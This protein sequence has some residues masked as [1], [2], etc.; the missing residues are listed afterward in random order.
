[1]AALLLVL[2]LA[3]SAAADDPVR[4][5]AGRDGETCRIVI[6]GRPYSLPADEARIAAHLQSVKRRQRRARLVLTNPDTPYRCIGGL[7]YQA[8]RI[9]LALGFIAEQPPR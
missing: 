8:Q 6:E 3:A 1:M 5:V 4:V 2:A 7:I 9:G